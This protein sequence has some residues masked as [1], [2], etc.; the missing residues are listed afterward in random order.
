M[1]SGSEIGERVHQRRVE[2]GLSIRELA[3]RTDLSASFI[4]QLERGKVNVSVDSLQRLASQLN[5]SI[6]YFLPQSNAK[7]I[8]TGSNGSRLVRDNSLNSLPQEYTPVVELENRPKLTLPASG[9]SYE[10]LTNDLNRKMEAIFERLQPGAVKLARP[11]REPT[12]EFIYLLSGSLAVD[13]VTGE[14]I[15]YPGDS[16][17]F[18][19]KFLQRLACASRS[20]DAVWIAVITPPVL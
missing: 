7:N 16:I 11:L 18:E 3:R 1:S 15:L 13:L 20:E 6:L 5:V 8:L 9:V 17:Y 14:H 2:L 4:S 19:G 10:L 12:E